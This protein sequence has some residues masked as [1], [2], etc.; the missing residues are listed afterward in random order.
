VFD[1]VAWL[2]E[3]ISLFSKKEVKK[4]L[5]LVAVV[6]G[7]YF[8][9][10]GSGT[11]FSPLG[12]TFSMAR[13]IGWLLATGFPF[14]IGSSL[15]LCSD[16]TRNS[17]VEHTQTHEEVKFSYLFVSYTIL[18]LVVMSAVS[19]TGL[20]IAVIAAGNVA[21][22]GIFPQL[23]GIT[24]LISLLLTPIYALIAIEFDSMSKSI[25][26]GFFLSIALVATTGQPGYPT[27]YPEVAFFGPAHLL[28]ALL[29]IAIGAYGNYNVDYYVGTTFQPI[30]LITPILVWSVLAIIC[31]FW[32]K[33]VFINNLSR[34]TKEREGWLS[35]G[36]SKTELDE[37]TLPANLP[38]IRREL[39]RRQRYAVAISIAIIILIS[40]GG[41]S[42]V[43]V[44]QG[45]WT[46]VVYESPSEGESVEIGNW[47]YGSFTG[48][49]PSGSI[50][51]G[52]TCE[53]RILDWSGG[54]GQVYFTFEHREMTLSEFQE[55][56]ETEFSDLFDHSESG[57]LASTG[58]FGGGLC[59]P[60]RD[61]EYV[62]VLRFNDVNGRTSGSVDIWFQVIIR[63]FS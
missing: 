14:V 41:F 47:L 6:F 59:G 58:T 10:G 20:L 49:E 9:I 55:L 37:S 19:F 51:L 60:L 35:S 40:L 3:Y 52:V 54:T 1:K 61:V 21:I 30:H 39:Y 23:V 4:W 29:F 27:N 18:T 53:G 38:I 24:L 33:R 50:S 36:Q 48:V 45:E 13:T 8:L 11:W 63:A 2:R 42:Y 7:F 15:L 34:W 62:W 28:S 46:Q 16:Q 32:A 12:A 56:N 31:Y 43:Q 57:N 44:R 5:I 17:I 26:I 22:L 25:V